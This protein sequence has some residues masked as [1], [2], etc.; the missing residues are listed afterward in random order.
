MR[1]KGKL[2][3]EDEQG[4]VTLGHLLMGIALFM[5]A[6]MVVGEVRAVGGGVL[7]YLLGLPLALVLGGLVVLLQWHS[8]KFFWQRSQR[9]CDRAQN[10]VAIGLFTLDLVWIMLAGICGYRLAHLVIKFF[11]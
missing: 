1:Q 3:T 11:V 6:A 8:G 9:Y 7:R 5:P 4:H 10:I 2:Q